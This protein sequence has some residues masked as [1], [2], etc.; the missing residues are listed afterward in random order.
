LPF[1]CPRLARTANSLRRQLDTHEFIISLSSQRYSTKPALETSITSDINITTTK[2]ATTSNRNNSSNSSSRVKTEPKVN[3]KLSSNGN[4]Q[5]SSQSDTSLFIIKP[6]KHPS[7]HPRSIK[8]PTESSPVS[9]ETQISIPS[10]SK[11]NPVKNSP[12]TPKDIQYLSHLITL[13]NAKEAYLV[14]SLL[15]QHRS[16]DLNE[17]TNTTLWI[18]FI[19]LTSELNDIEDASWIVYNRLRKTPVAKQLKIQHYQNI[20]RHCAP[21][22]S[23]SRAIILLD[24]IAKLKIT[25]NE[26]TEKHQIQMLNDILY[27]LIQKNLI[28]DARKLI[29]NV[30]RWN[31]TPNITTLGI[32]MGGYMINHDKPKLKDINLLAANQGIVLNLENCHWILS[33]LIQSGYYRLAYSLFKMHPFKSVS[34]S[35]SIMEIWI[36]GLC[37]EKEI[38]SALPLYKKLKQMSKISNIQLYEAVMEGI[39]IEKKNPSHALFILKEIKKYD[40]E[41]TLSMYTSIM[42]GHLINDDIPS[43]IKIFEEIQNKKQFSSGHNLHQLIIQ[44]YCSRQDLQSAISLFNTMN[45][46]G[47]PADAHTCGTLI[48]AYCQSGC[49]HVAIEM[50]NRMDLLHVPVDANGLR[51]IIDGCIQEGLLQTSIKLIQRILSMGSQPNVFSYIDLIESCGKNGGD[52]SLIY[53]LIQECQ[54]YG[55]YPNLFIYTALIQYY[56]RIEDISNAMTVFDMMEKDHI[57]PTLSGVICILRGLVKKR[58]MKLASSFFERMDKNKNKLD[59]IAY[60][61]LMNGYCR[62]GDLDKS[63]NLF[64]R[65]KRD[66]IS[67]TIVTYGSLIH[68]Y[69]RLGDMSKAMDMYYMMKEDGLIPNIVIINTLIH[70]FVT[71]QKNLEKAMELYHQLEK[72]YHIKPNV[73]TFGL[74]FH[75]FRQT[76]NWKMIQD[77][78][79]D[80]ERY[81]L[82][83][84]DSVRRV[85]RELDLHNKN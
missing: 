53:D 41:P 50:L 34:L 2:T 52:F 23:Q 76:K 44:A 26:E 48:E 40:I 47:I 20:V 24:A 72:Q 81:N 5:L 82:P 17:L 10:N 49:L 18:E 37:Q 7:C 16:N 77:L 33:E 13:G 42:K 79:M 14:F 43:A 35:N 9:S 54:I 22:M 28:E 57:E 66:G 62:Q 25:K 45:D 15:N 75:G 71:G 11:K 61:I 4:H 12:L 60:T 29:A 58:S 36:I 80:M 69:C 83:L 85:I 74:L 73:M 32:L 65:M 56:G 27:G 70:G 38:L 31:L 21:F 51:C 59:V 19:K 39:C 46:Q 55:T 1:L 3:I 6:K 64:Q 67:P 84:N 63:M 78:R 8:S 30:K 68:G